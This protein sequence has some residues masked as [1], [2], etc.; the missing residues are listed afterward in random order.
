[1]LRLTKGTLSKEKSY[2]AKGLWIDF[3]RKNVKRSLSDFKMKFFYSWAEKKEDSSLFL[4]TWLDGAIK[5][6]NECHKYR[7]MFQLSPYQP[8]QF[9]YNFEKYIQNYL[10]K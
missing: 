1:M 4:F 3:K 2:Y 10:R 6:L 5:Y 8:L 9:L 7:H